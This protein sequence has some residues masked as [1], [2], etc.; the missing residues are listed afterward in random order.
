M[1]GKSGIYLSL[2]TDS[3]FH[4]LII[5]KSIG[6]FIYISAVGYAGGGEYEEFFGK[7]NK[8]RANSP[9]GLY[10]R[11]TGSGIWDGKLTSFEFNEDSKRYDLEVNKFIDIPMDAKDEEIM[12][13]LLEEICK[14]IYFG[15][16]RETDEEYEY[17]KAK[18]VDTSIFTKFDTNPLHYHN[19]HWDDEWLE[20]TLTEIW[21]LSTSFP[22]VIGY[23]Q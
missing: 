8:N 3:V 9:V 14:Y 21:G 12:G 19:K 10:S 15:Y 17:P 7:F 13:N 2:K 6:N 20:V 23:Y 18:P 22:D 4:T 11:S 5:K 1:E 16:D